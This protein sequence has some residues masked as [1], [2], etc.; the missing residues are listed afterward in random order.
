MRDEVYLSK[1]EYLEILKV[2][3]IMVCILDRSE[4][5]DNADNRAYSLAIACAETDMAKRLTSV[6]KLVVELIT[7]K[8]LSELDDS[9]VFNYEIPQIPY[10]AGLHKL[11]E[12][13]KPYLV[14]YEKYSE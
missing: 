13:L 1:K 10:D 6:R 14:K 7:P 9:G 5:R 4:N 8:E 2:L 11:R 12:Q 3:D